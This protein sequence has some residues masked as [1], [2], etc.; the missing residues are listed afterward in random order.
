[1][2]VIL[3]RRAAARSVDHDGIQPAVVHFVRPRADIGG[4]AVVAL[5]D[6]AHVVGQRPAATRA[7][8]HDHF[9]PQTG[10]QANGGVVD[11]CVQR[12]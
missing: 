11:V 12:L 5:V 9:A 8:G 2:A 3:H 10:Q 6:L 4:G 1:M 7:F